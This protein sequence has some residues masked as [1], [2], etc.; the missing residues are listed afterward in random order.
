MAELTT[1]KNLISAEEVLRTE[2]IVNQALIDILIA[3]QVI[4][5]EELVNSIQKIRQEQMELLNDSNKIVSL[6]R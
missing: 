1:Q 6:Q 2:I 3:K 5:E 4:S